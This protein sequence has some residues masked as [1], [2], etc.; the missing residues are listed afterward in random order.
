MRSLARR[1][2]SLYPPAWRARYGDD[3]RDFLEELEEEN[4][5][6][7]PALL[8]LVW[9][10]VCMR[11]SG[12][13]TPPLASAWRHRS[14]AAISVATAP[15]VLFLPVL[16]AGFTTS[17][18]GNGSAPLS[19][20]GIVAEK[21]GSAAGILTLATFLALLA[22]WNLLASLSGEVAPRHR[23][24]YSAL[25]AAPFVLVVL[26]FGL[27][28]L[29]AHFATFAWL[30]SVGIAAIWSAWGAGAALVLT[31]GRLAP[32]SAE[33]VRRGAR[34]AVIVAACTA[35]LFFSLLVRLVALSLQPGRLRIV[36]Q[37]ACHCRLLTVVGR[38]AL[39]GSSL[40]SLAPLWLALAFAACLVSTAGAAAA[41]RSGRTA[42][43]L[44]PAREGSGW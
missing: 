27:M 7:L 41:L 29:G 38:D 25:V 31:S 34:V 2:V 16:L 32:A 43:L 39:V 17:Y 15:A 13:G 8:S 9:G 21:A 42:R 3:V 5:P 40:G 10:A 35:C 1:V 30:R 4:R 12:A 26:A 36:V 14:R 6:F 28:A 44:E 20:A 18:Y 23:R 19:T 22:G 33:A 11:L 24:A 37:P